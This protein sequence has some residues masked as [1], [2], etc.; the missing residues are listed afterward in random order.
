MSWIHLPRLPGH[1]YKGKFLWEIGGMVGK[2]AKL[3][4]NNSNKARGIF[5][6]MAIYVNLD[7]PLVS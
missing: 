4:F 2:V 1:M 6:R 7:K 5:A 3:D